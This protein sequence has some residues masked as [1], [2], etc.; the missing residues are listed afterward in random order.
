MQVLCTSRSIKTIFQGF[1]NYTS[2]PMICLPLC[3]PFRDIFGDVSTE[4]VYIRLPNKLNHSDCSSLLTK[5]LGGL[6]REVE[7]YPE[8]FDKK[9][10]CITIRSVV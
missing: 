9:L 2:N 1:W 3:H 8:M 10:V 6:V 7:V 5:L 4:S